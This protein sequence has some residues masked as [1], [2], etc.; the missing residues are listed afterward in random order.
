MTIEIDGTIVFWKNQKALESG[1]RF[2]INEGG[3]RSSKTYSL[4]QLLISHA[5]QND[6][7][8]ISVVRKTFPSLRATV[9]RDFVEVLHSMGL[10][11]KQQH[12][13]SEHIYTFDNGSMVEFFSV[14]DEQKIRG[15]KRDVCWCNEANELLFDDFT[16]LN[17]RTTDKIILDYNPSESSSWL[18]EVDPKESITIKSTYKD[19]PFLDKNIIKAIED[20]KRTDED[21]YQIYALGKRIISKQNIYRGWEFLEQKPERFRQFIYGLDFGYQHPTALTRIWW[22]EKDLF[23]EPVI[24]ESYMTSADIVA[25]FNSLGIEKNVEIMADYARPEIIYELRTKG[26][27]VQDADKS[28]QSGINSVKTFKVYCQENEHA[29][30]EYENY[31]YKKVKDNITDDPVKLHDD[32]MDSVRYGVKFIRDY[33]FMNDGYIAF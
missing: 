12:N 11:S 25:R 24:Y 17:M 7:I 18:Y 8:T 33:Y 2:I 19:N 23:L 4:C 15:R 20:L 14:D 31:K 13:K 26:Y 10:Y 27:N 22:D 5:L 29:R 30:K 32:F 1:K 16:Q 3:S 9:Y 6:N 21:L 28:V